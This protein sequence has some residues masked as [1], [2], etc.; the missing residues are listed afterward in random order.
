MVHDI[1]TEMKLTILSLSLATG[2]AGAFTVSPATVIMVDGKS[3]SLRNRSSEAS[4]YR[5]RLHSKLLSSDQ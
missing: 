1:L 4:G 2:E 5:D 3:L